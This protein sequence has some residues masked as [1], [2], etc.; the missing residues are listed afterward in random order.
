MRKRFSDEQYLYGKSVVSIRQN[1]NKCYVETSDSTLHE[2]DRIIGAD[3]VG[4]IVRSTLFH[5]TSLQHA[6]YIAWRGL[7]D[8]QAIVNNELFNSYAPCYMFSNGHLLMYRIPAPD[9]EHTGKMFL[10]WVMYEYNKKIPLYEL[11]TDKEGVQRSISI[12][13]GMLSESRVSHLHALANQVLPAS[14]AEIIGQ[15][16]TPFIQAVF[17]Y[18][19]PRYV[20]GRIC[21]LGDSGNTKRPHTASGLVTAIEGGLA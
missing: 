16:S 5:E 18:Q 14:L 6:N 4:S 7:I 21:L 17:D 3:G 8:D 2:F 19:A 10:N 11:L 12:P 15:T 1:E 20:E 13:P 9:Y